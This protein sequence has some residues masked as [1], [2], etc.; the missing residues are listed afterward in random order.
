MT[1]PGKRVWMKQA[2]DMIM[3]ERQDLVFE[4]PAW[5]EGQGLGAP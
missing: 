1:L 4:F 5:S 2:E 3:P